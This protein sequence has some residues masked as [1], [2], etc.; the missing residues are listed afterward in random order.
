M[1]L[2][3]GGKFEPD[4]SEQRSKAANPNGKKIARGHRTA[5]CKRSPQAVGGRR[6]FGV[7]FAISRGSSVVAW[8]LSTFSAGRIAVDC[9]LRAI[10]ENVGDFPAAE[11]A[12]GRTR[13]ESCCKTSLPH[14]RREQHVAYL[15]AAV[16][17]VRK[18]QWR[19]I[20]STYERS[21]TLRL[22][23][24][25]ALLLRPRAARQA[26]YP[27]A[28]GRSLRAAEPSLRRLRR[29]RRKKAGQTGQGEFAPGG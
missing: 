7:C 1:P 11:I 16:G 29:Q 18:Q 6:R 17:R 27:L 24:A 14:S 4:W 8:W 21:S 13:V 25:K 19:C 15:V 3:A 2:R 12:V 10:K 22:T 9:P 26:A 28:A 20:E 5:S 23:P